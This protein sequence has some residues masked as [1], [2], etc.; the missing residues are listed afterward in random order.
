M[1]TMTV[2][3]HCHTTRNENLLEFEV[4]RQIIPPGTGLSYF[5]PESAQ[6]HPLAKALFGIR[7]VAGLYILGN[8]V[9]V[10]K[11]ENIRWGSITSQVEETLKATLNSAN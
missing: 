2:E 10:S 1:N 6:H 7:G 11:E 9:H 4:N 5:D 3:V 8:A